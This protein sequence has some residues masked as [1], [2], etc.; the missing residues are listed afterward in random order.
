MKLGAASELCDA[1]GRAFTE[2]YK[3]F[4]FKDDDDLKNYL[5]FVIH[6]PAEWMRGFPAS[7]KNAGHFSKVRAAFHRLLKHTSVVADLD[8]SYT[9]NVHNL[10][11]GA[12][13]T[14]MAEILE[15]R[16]GAIVS[17]DAAS[18]ALT[19]ESCEADLPL[20]TVLRR[21]APR[22]IAAHVLAV[23]EPAA[24]AASAA[25]AASP[26]PFVEPRNSVILKKITDYKH[27]YEV[28]N[29]VLMSLLEKADGFDQESQRMRAAMRI[30][31]DEFGRA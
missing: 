16:N 10:I 17:D 19:A 5:D 26:P 23:N 21:S 3:I 22:T 4:N 7:W 1:N 27:K 30:L 18:V 25:H 28:L 13:K 20:P 15:K 14:H 29:R 11:W 24:P 2:V 31:L 9:E 8:T 6:E 12:F